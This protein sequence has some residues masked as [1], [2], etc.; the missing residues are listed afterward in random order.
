[1]DLPVR[2][3][4]AL[5]ETLESFNYYEE[6][7]MLKSSLV[8]TDPVGTCKNSEERVLHRCVFNEDVTDNSLRVHLAGTVADYIKIAEQR[9]DWSVTVTEDPSYEWRKRVECVDHLGRLR[10]VRDIAIVSAWEGEI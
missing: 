1:M 9:K 10:M 4:K 2:Y 8:V 7:N 5:A 6:V 3:N